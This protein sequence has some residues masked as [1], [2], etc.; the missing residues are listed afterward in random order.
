[1]IWKETKRVTNI[2]N[3][4]YMLQ[5]K[6][7]Q[8]PNDIYLTE[9]LHCWTELVGSLADTFSD[10]WRSTSIPQQCFTM[11]WYAAARFSLPL[12]AWWLSYIIL[13]HSSQLA[14]GNSKSQL[15][16]L[17]ISD[18]SAFVFGRRITLAGR[19]QIFTS[20]SWRWLRVSPIADYNY[21][22]QFICIQ[23]NSFR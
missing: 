11:S 15:G 13:I 20:S 12:I 17:S 22:K 8:C 2:S 5:R 16:M 3:A 14:S 18:P 7:L 1:M 23:Y 6:V 21:N 10:A 19:G 4:I 9:E